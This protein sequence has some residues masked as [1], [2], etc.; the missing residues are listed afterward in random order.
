MGARRF[1]IASAVTVLL[2][3]C[4]RLAAAQGGDLGTIAGV[5]RDT[6]GAVL[7]GVTVEVSSPSLIEKVRTAVTDEQGQYKISPLRP[8]VYSVTFSL[9]GFST[10]KREGVELTASFTATVNADMKLGSLE[11]TITVSGQ[12]PVVD[13]QNTVQQQAITAAV[14]EAI[15]SGRTFQALAQLI[16]GISRSSG[17]D[18]G[19][20][21]GDRFSTLA[22]HGSRGGEM[23][24]IFDGMRYNNMNG[25]GGGGLTN[26]MINTGSVQEM[27]VQ[28]AGAS[29]ENQVSGVFINVIP[30]EGAN[31]FKGE[32]FVTGANGAFQSD[33]LTDA[34][35]NAGLTNVTTVN[36][37]WDIN[38]GVGGPVVRDRVWF[39]T[40]VRY[41]G[42]IRDVGGMWYNATPNTPLFTPDLARQ[43]DEGDT[44]LVSANA[45]ATFQAS[46]R[47]K[48]T[49][50]YANSQRLIARRNTS[51]TVA[52]EAAE[53]YTTPRNGLYQVSWSSPVTNRL[54]IE[55]GATFYPSTFTNCDSSGG[56]GCQPEVSASAIAIQDQTLG[57]QYGAISGR[58]MFTDLSF[59]FNQKLNVSYITGSHAFR[60]GMQ[61]ISGYHE[62]PSWVLNDVYYQFA[63]TVPRSITQFTT[64]YNTIDRLKL[65]PSFFVQDQWTLKSLTAT[66]GLRLDFLNA[67]VPAQHLDATRFV[68]ARDFA[69]V[70]N[71]PDWTD[72]S[73][74][75]GISYDVFGTGKT[76]IKA[77]LNRYVQS[78]TLALAMA[79]NPVVTSVLSATRT[80]TD[81]D[82]DYVPDCDLTNPEANGECLALNNRN[83]GRNNPN[84]TRYDPDVLTGFQKRPFDW[85]FM[86]GLQ[87]ELRPG[88]AVSGMFFRHWFGNHYVTHNTAL[89]AADFDSYCITS[90]TSD[91]R[92]ADGG[93]P[94]CGLYDVKT[95]SFGT[96]S[97]MVTF[98]KNFGE[99]QEVYT[100]VDLNVNARLPR[101]AFV[102]GGATIGRTMSD[103][104]YSNDLPQLS[105][106]GTAGGVNVTP[107][108]AEFCRVDPPLSSGT[109]VKFVGTYPFPWNI[110]AA[111]TFQNVPGPQITAVYAAPTAV[112][113]AG[114]L[115]NPNSAVTTDLVPAGTLFQD[116]INQ[117]DFRVSRLFRADR[118]QLKA[119]LDI[120]N[121]FNS[122]AIEGQNNTFGPN[123]QRPTAIMQGRLFKLSAQVDW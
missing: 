6:T 75:V 93:S 118:I 27:S 64:P 8:G 121:A 32:L 70:D 51:P 22:V 109:Q 74:R 9:T 107:R 83:F 12:S 99:Q 68:P 17:Q 52:P 94:I 106:A 104:C 76:A 48:F 31:A 66:Y 29:V 38:P 67:Y 50:Y 26:F 43:A 18:V 59:A 72:L 87:H 58:A 14:I 89:T 25:S 42:N 53:R 97:N 114:L 1:S 24:L 122:S 4:S 62:R 36:R 54:F 105:R 34:I 30:K 117:L 19:G 112:V 86:T 119:N 98:S 85:E 39:Y 20:L 120:Y 71:V 15:P 84:A 111:A 60:F 3:G 33:N 47:N 35:K 23:P 92:L 95:A 100:G 65:S 57:L 81:A 28:T 7:P 90:P 55:T 115:R 10:I 49:G 77:S 13:V 69:R 78:Q 56:V 101:G 40:S 5:A 61:L 113:A 41:W 88:L 45:R 110:S 73:P 44:W 21:G 108:T 116:R 63:N 79:V 2:V 80:W 103:Q 123:W 11:E 37:I 91:S 82:R 96:V 46:P 102:Q 16:P